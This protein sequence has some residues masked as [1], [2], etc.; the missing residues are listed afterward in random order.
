MAKLC[1]IHYN[2][3]FIFILMRAISYFLRHIYREYYDD[4]FSNRNFNLFIIFFGESLTMLFYL[5]VKKYLVINNKNKKV[6]R[7]KKED[8]KNKFSFFIYFLIFFCAGLDLTT[9]YYYIDYFYYK[10]KKQINQFDEIKNFFFIIIIFF[11]ENIYLNKPN[12]GHHYLGI[13]LCCISLIIK[14]INFSFKDYKTALLLF[15]YI[16]CGFCLSAEILIEKSLNFDYFID[17]YFICAFEG[18]FG[19]ILVILIILIFYEYES[20]FAFIR[21]FDIKKFL[22][23]MALDCVIT[24]WYNI[25]RLKIV[26]KNRASYNS[27]GNILTDV[28]IVIF[29]FIIKEKNREFLSIFS[30]IFALVGCLIFCEVIVLNFW[31]LDK[32]TFDM[33]S[34]RGINES[35]DMEENKINDSFDE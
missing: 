7:I 5:M 13:F 17:I 22:L 16:Q 27:I 30:L 28:L 29:E 35:L 34:K 11:F 33:T 26:E 21:I 9:S 2:N 31:N 8:S 12:Y 24:L 15:V 18:I 4:Y 19:I 23:V 3:S 25:S 1:I 6:F 20:I 10:D 32:Y 14:I